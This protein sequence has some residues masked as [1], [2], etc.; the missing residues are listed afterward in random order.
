MKH[1]FLATILGFLL[2]VFYSVSAQEVKVKA[3]LDTSSILI[4]QQVDLKLSVSIASG[5]KIVWP[6]IGDSIAAGVEV[7]SKSKIDTVFSTDKKMLDLIQ[8][9]RITSFDSGIHVLPFIPFYNSESRDS[10][11]II[12]QT[13]SLMLNVQ[14]IQVD[15]TR[16]F[17]DS[18]GP[19]GIPITFREMLPWI[20][21]GLGVIAIISFIVYYFIRKKK[22]KP[23]LM[24]SA[25]PEL[26]P[27][28]AALEDLE[29]LRMAKL[30]QSGR[31]KEYHTALTDI[32]RI[33]IERKYQIMAMEMTSDEIL[34]SLKYNKVPNEARSALSD[35]FV[36]SDLVKFA[37]ANP[38]PDE[39]D[40]SLKK[41]VEF[42]K[43][44]TTEL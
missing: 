29:K 27:H 28:V 6:L 17:K 4:G 10:S 3:N 42:V 9:V 23:L 18:K 36:L 38:L 24:F 12:A 20:L 32:I 19:L 26:P 34:S 8:R 43:L 2:A 41:S 40:I 16:A 7:V 44:T 35:I 39:H 25:K 37:K 21:G 13:E 14:T 33:Y 15:T 5:K 11:S 30:W 1:T 22:D 31:V